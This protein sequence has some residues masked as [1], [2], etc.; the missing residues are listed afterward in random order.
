MGREEPWSPPE[1]GSRED[2][3]LQW[4]ALAEPPRGIVVPPA[5]WKATARVS[6]MKVPAI[7]RLARRAAAGGDPRVAW[8]AAHLERLGRR[9]PRGPGDLRRV[10]QADWLRRR[11][12]T[13]RRVAIACGYSV[14]DSGADAR[15]AVKLYREQ[16]ENGGTLPRARKAYQL[17][18]NGE[19]WPQIA[20]RVGYRSGRAAM[21]MSRRYAA[22]AGLPWPVPVCDAA[23]A[24]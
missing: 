12:L 18:A 6:G 5:L 13:W 22:R 3:A 2:R 21:G 7:K 9:T 11:G 16:L 19:T 24:D 17:R 8:L 20:R 1:R 15:R 4:L 10:R 14:R 23:S